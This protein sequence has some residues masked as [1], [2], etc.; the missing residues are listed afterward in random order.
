MPD[1]CTCVMVLLGCAVHINGR[2]YSLP[3]HRFPLGQPS[4][5]P[6]HT[7]IS[8]KLKYKLPSSPYWGL[9]H[10]QPQSFAGD[11]KLF[12]AAGRR[13]AKCDSSVP[14]T[15]QQSKQP[16][17]T[18]SPVHLTH[19]LSQQLTKGSS[20]GQGAAS[21]QL[22]PPPGVWGDQGWLWESSSQPPVPGRQ[23]LHPGSGH[24]LCCSHSLQSPFC[25][26][27]HGPSPTPGAAS[28]EPCQ[29]EF[30]TFGWADSE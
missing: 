9:F 19:Q 30:T 17:V 20:L 26:S 15:V 3:G 27:G 23:L 25:F 29:D 5:L 8:R 7:S 2:H 12:L 22:K 6:S 16:A 18:T 14:K 21:I 4:L 11:L 1:V 28:K 13:K 24:C 10:S